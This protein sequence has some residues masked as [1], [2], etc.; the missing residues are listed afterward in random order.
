M[1]KMAKSDVKVIKAGKLIDGTGAKAVDNATVVV[2]GNKIKEVGQ[3]VQIPE[4]ATIIDASK[5]TVMPGMIDAHI[6]F[7]G[8]FADDTDMDAY[9]RPREVRLIKAVQDAKDYLGRGFT[10]A[11]ECGG[12]NGL[13]MRRAVAD[14]VLSGIPRIISS[15]YML[16]NTR[17]A[18]QNKYLPNEYLDA[19]T[20][21]IKGSVGG[22][23][24]ICDGVDE[25][26]KAARYTLSQGADFIKVVPSA[27]SF[28]TADELKA[29]G[30]IAEYQGKFITSHCDTARQMK[31]TMLAGGKT[32]DHAVEADDEVIEMANK[33]GVVFVSTLSV[34]QCIVDYAKE[35]K[36]EQHGKE[37]AKGML[38]KMGGSYRRIRE[39]GG[40]LAI[41]TDLGGES[42]MENVGTSA[43]EIELLTRYSG[44]SNMDAIVA[45][46]KYGA[47]ACALGD[48]TGTLE[49]GKFADIIVL[50]GDPL[51]DIKVLQNKEKV[52]VVMLEGKVEV[53]RR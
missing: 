50:D 23:Y 2:E 42:L 37:W 25:C 9:S 17:G 52:K 29:I 36:R 39:G 11:R 26:I 47:M 28:F 15:A 16:Q 33:R 41:G 38:A 22:N 1:N 3:R 30:L 32:L 43:L 48:K 44:F 27:G 49:A 40:K 35:A 5:M 51:A 13:Y 46:T 4:G 20:S 18:P 10:T 19:R 34:M 14:G 7:G 24:I 6:H 53:D 45:A 8:V 12:M 21:R 31:E